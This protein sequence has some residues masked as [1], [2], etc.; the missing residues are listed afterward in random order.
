MSEKHRNLIIILETV[1]IEQFFPHWRGAGRPEEPRAALARA[2]I[3]KAV[4]NLPTTRALIDW[5]NADARLRR[6]CGFERVRD[7]P[8]EW[9]FSRAFAEFAK[10]AL[11]AQVHAAL[12]HQTLSTQLVGHISRDST[13]IEARERPEWKPKAALPDKALKRGRRRKG[14]EAP[15]KEIRRIDRQ[16]DQSLPAMCADLPKTC[17]IGTKRN[18]KGHQESWIGYKLHIDTADGDIPVSAILTSA[19]LHDSQAAIPLATMTGQRVY[20]LYTLMDSAYDDDGIRQHEADRGHVAIIDINPRRDGV[21]KQDLENETRARRKIHMPSAEDIRYRQRSS[22][23][24]VNSA[25]K[26]N[27]GGRSVRVRGNEKVAAHLMF[28]LLA[29]TAIQLMRLVT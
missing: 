6:L 9:T 14:E 11:P 25:L 29:L 4:F 26:D 18:A 2:F 8:G 5:L 15:I 7:V 1:C 24:R 13:A 28:G 16:R 21:L 20:S 3:A 17:A 10:S 23:E 19:S 22:A 12:I 27:Y